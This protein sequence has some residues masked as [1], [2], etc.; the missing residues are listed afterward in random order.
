MIVTDILFK[1]KCKDKDTWVEGFYFNMPDKTRH[2]EESW[3]KDIIPVGSYIASPSQDGL[4]MH[5]V[6]PIT[7]C[8]WTGMEDWKGKK[9]WEHDIL[10]CDGNPGELMEVVFGKFNLVTRPLFCPVI[11][12]V[13]GWHCVRYPLGAMEEGRCK[14]PRILR[15]GDTKFYR[16]EVIKNIFDDKRCGKNEID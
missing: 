2:Y 13:T 14:C 16:F 3:R 4:E 9:I 1:A 10:M 11:E 8:I 5:E 15:E 12:E 6:D 7:V